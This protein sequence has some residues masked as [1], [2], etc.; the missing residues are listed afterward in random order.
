MFSSVLVQREVELA[1]IDRQLGT[2]A[3]GEGGMLLLEG[4]AGIGK[5]ALLRAARDRAQAAGMTVLHSQGGELERA[6]AW[7][8]ARELLQPAMAHLDEELRSTMSGGPAEP[9][10]AV[11]DGGPVDDWE[12][13]D[14][15]FRVA[16]A[17]TW[18]VVGLADLRPVLLAV[19]DAH[20]S[21]A[22]SLRWLTFL[23]RRLEGVRVL[24]IVAARPAEASA[25]WSLEQLA[26]GARVVRPR[27][28]GPEA[29]T[30]VVT[31]HFS[32]PPEEGFTAAC[33]EVSGGNPFL[34]NEL[35][36]EASAARLRPLASVA[37]SVRSLRPASV[38]RALV[39]RLARLERGALEL[40]RAV[41]ILG[42]G[43]SPSTAGALAGLPEPAT[44][45]AA[46]A[47]TAAEVLADDAALRFVHPLVRAAIYEDIAPARR[48]I[49]H[50]RAAR[51]LESRGAD[52][53]EIASQLVP[54]ERTGDAWAVERLLAA[55]RSARLSGAPEVA[56]E[57]A[58]R[59]LA[60]PPGNDERAT[61]LDELGT[62]DLDLGA[63]SGI[64]HLQA[65]FSMARS[66]VQRA[67]VALR[68]ARALH[69]LGGFADG[70]RV[71]AAGIERL[72]FEAD[73]ELHRALES[74][75]ILGATSDP[76]TLGLAR[77]RLEG[78]LAR[79]PGS[80]DELD[81]GLLAH[82]AAGAAAGGHVQE[83]VALAQRAL[84]QP[85]P[86]TPSVPLV[87][88]YALLPLRWADRLDECLRILTAEVEEAR[89]RS[90]PVRLA[91]ASGTR[92]Q[93]LLRL[94]RPQAAEPDARLGVEL[95]EAVFPIPM[96]IALS[97]HAETLLEIG[98]P[99]EAR[100]VLARA[101]LDDGGHDVV[102]NAEPLR[103]RA[104]VR[105]DDGD[106][107][108]ALADLN[109]IAEM[110]ERY[111]LVHP[112][113]M[114]WRAQAALVHAALD[115]LPIAL[116]LIEEEIEQAATVG[117][118]WMLGGALRVRGQLHQDCGL[119]DL[120]EAVA[121]LRTG[122]DRLE[123]IRALLDF[124]AALRRSGQRTTARAPLREALDLAAHGG[125]TMLADRARVELGATGARPRRDELRGRDALTPSER[126][127]VMLAA[128]GRTNRE[129][130]Q[131][132][133]VTMRTVETHL[134]HAYMKLDVQGRDALAGVLA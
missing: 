58:A 19:D 45:A 131:A 93:I 79:Q 71:A 104:R 30:D 75:L 114:P 117:S 107:P 21:D 109:R 128:E 64:A 23:A 14:Q 9:A 35:L 38:R 74:Q 80:I 122:Q 44:A 66:D 33:L 134:T 46:D 76:E 85:A 37:G 41:A 1:A 24:A 65:A 94:G 8:V 132:L 31:A 83:G 10:A 82:L 53:G 115:E 127:V 55:A 105:A 36:H 98:E 4:A 39:P 72:S 101:R 78:A 63:P 47:L 29:V 43:V 111:E 49:E 68:L 13:P 113:A 28:L 61:V 84:A 116:R 100:A 54:A 102:T 129:I 62:A 110:A 125:A 121:V 42:D 25:D 2:V 12:G 59:A 15:A 69:S 97:I 26:A 57:L 87:V 106:L 32:R 11:L 70:A 112:A 18:L 73:P 95:N 103:I 17:L 96:P 120:G 119:D 7:A 67:R 56:H 50:R 6:A 16:H 118:A 91:W 130:A 108:G 34:L 123:H 48:A 90:A 77:S 60:E 126:R 3:G 22:A 5:T 52:D 81:P 124:G 40:A 88:E 51:L 99:Q 92:A 89:R 86:S 27:P 20:W 133:F